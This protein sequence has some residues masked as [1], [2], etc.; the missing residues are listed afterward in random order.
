MWCTVR[1]AANA[2]PPRARHR[3]G[4]RA[5]EPDNFATDLPLFRYDGDWSCLADEPNRKEWVDAVKYI[6]LAFAGL[7]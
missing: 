6:P 5:T 7:L 2:L 4:D 1:D 3:L